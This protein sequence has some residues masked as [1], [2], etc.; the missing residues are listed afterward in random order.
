MSTAPITTRRQCFDLSKIMCRS[1]LEAFRSIVEMEHFYESLYAELETFR[2]SFGSQNPSN[3]EKTLSILSTAM[4]FY[5]SM[6]SYA[7]CCASLKPLFNYS[8]YRVPLLRV[9]CHWVTSFMP[10][11][12]G[13]DLI[14]DVSY[15]HELF[16]AP[17]S[18]ASNLI[19]PL[20]SS[21]KW[22]IRVP[23]LIKN[24]TSGFPSSVCL[25]VKRKGP[26][27]RFGGTD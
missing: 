6:T 15:K 27:L 11:T 8:Q 9:R 25:H 5:D 22:V 20:V 12:M 4:D 17:F 23:C 26:K 18:T 21:R 3:G 16:R 24:N 14:S 13:S 19:I 1:H 2:P 7:K 10:T